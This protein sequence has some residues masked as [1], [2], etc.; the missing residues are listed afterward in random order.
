MQCRL[1]DPVRKTTPMQATPSCRRTTGAFSAGNLSYLHD[2]RVWA[3]NRAGR[4][5]SKMQTRT[6]I[7]IHMDLLHSNTEST[8]LQ[9]AQRVADS[10]CMQPAR[11]QQRQC[12]NQVGIP[13][14]REG[15]GRVQNDLHATSCPVCQTPVADAA[16]TQHL[17]KLSSKRPSS[18][19]LCI[20]EA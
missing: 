1:Q 18:G 20:G 6:I 11:P 7:T 10:P 4:S 16:W 15:V 5:R 8:Q 14:L 19:S 12:T 9:A 13:L 2:R 17:P 3:C